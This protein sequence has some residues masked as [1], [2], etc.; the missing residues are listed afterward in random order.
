MPYIIPVK[1]LTCSLLILSLFNSIL[2]AQSVFLAFGDLDGPVNPSP[3]NALDPGVDSVNLALYGVPSVTITGVGATYFDGTD[4]SAKFVANNASLGFNSLGGDDLDA[5]AQWDGAESWTFKFDQD[6]TW[7][8]LGLNGVGG[9]ESGY[10]ESDA[11]IGLAYTPTGNGVT[12]DNITG[13]FTLGSNSNADN[14]VLADLTGGLELATLAEVEVTFGVAVGTVQLESFSFTV[15]PEVQTA[16]IFM[17]VF[18]M[19]MMLYRRRA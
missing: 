9:S 3:F 17:G 16:G 19:G 11:W 18:A 12:F 4:T 10:I 6:I 2:T 8:G 1:I 13:R 15:V 5:N 7:D 14:Y